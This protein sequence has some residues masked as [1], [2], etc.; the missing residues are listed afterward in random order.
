MKP[1]N[2]Q[3]N[4]VLN[5]ELVTCL[6]D[7]VVDPFCRGI[8]FSEVNMQQCYMFLDAFAVD[9]WTNA[10]IKGRSIFTLAQ[11]NYTNVQ[12]IKFV[13]GDNYPSFIRLYYKHMKSIANICG[14]NSLLSSKT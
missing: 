8:N 4:P 2:K 11:E 6:Q 5:N 10:W 12:M 9:N 3:T 7:C 14:Q 13:V 1:Y